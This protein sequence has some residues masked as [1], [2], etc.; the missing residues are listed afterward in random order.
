MP[1]RPNAG[2]GN[3][4]HHEISKT[5]SVEAF[6]E[7]HPCCASQPDRLSFT[8]KARKAKMAKI[9]TKHGS[10]I[11][12]EHY[13][14]VMRRCRRYLHSEDALTI[15][16]GPDR[17]HRAP[18]FEVFTQAQL[19][20][21][22]Y[23][24]GVSKWSVLFNG[25]AKTKQGEGT[26]FGVTYE[27]PVLEQSKIVLDAYHRLRNSSEGKL[28]FGMTIDDFSSDARYRCAMR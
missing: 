5:P 28:W 17:H 13:S 22:P 23:G 1:W 18:S 16:I 12:F 2:N 8:M 3:F 10:L 11:T 4:L 24:N 6:G 25:Q 26:K 20:P 21:A 7:Q 15:G 27:I 14:E 9:A 19:M